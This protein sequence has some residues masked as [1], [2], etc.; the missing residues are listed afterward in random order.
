MVILK[1][2]PSVSY[3]LFYQQLYIYTFKGHT[4]ILWE[5]LSGCCSCRPLTFSLIAAC[6]V[7]N[8]KIDAN[9]MVVLI[10]SLCD[11]VCVCVHLIFLLE[12]IAL[13]TFHL[14]DVL[15]KVCNSDSWLKLACLELTCRN[16][17]I[18]F[19]ETE[20]GEYI[21]WEIDTIRG[22][23]DVRIYATHLQF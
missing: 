7:V 21:H 13:S 19:K 18:L 9:V 15:E 2:H 5:L 20:R 17:N 3:S 14:G 6:N 1:E 11:C 8:L 4:N 23:M 10:T 22:W 16:R 12:A